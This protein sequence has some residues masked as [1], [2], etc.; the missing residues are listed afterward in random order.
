MVHYVDVKIVKL[1]NTSRLNWRSSGRKYSQRV[2]ND[3]LLV[4][5]IFTYK[6]SVDGLEE[7]PV[8]INNDLE[9]YWLG[10]QSLFSDRWLIA[11]LSI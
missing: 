2:S 4:R 8:H 10:F 11:S 5:L 6:L 9:E 1:T 7:P 3:V